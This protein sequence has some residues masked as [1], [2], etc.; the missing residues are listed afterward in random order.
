MA[1]KTD[2]FGYKLNYDKL[3]IN[4][5]NIFT[6]PTV[7]EETVFFI[8]KG[9]TKRLLFAADEIVS[10]TSYD[11]KTVYKAGDD[12]ALIDGKLHITENSSIPCITSEKYYY[13]SDSIVAIHKDGTH[14]PVYWGEDSTMVQWQV[15]VTYKHSDAFCGFSQPDNS[16]V[17][18]RF[19]K[20][21]N[22]ENSRV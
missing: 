21:L 16:A 7:F 11:R 2:I 19:I 3:D 9:E 17:Y 8:D 5:K 20:K 10:V 12:Y 13:V 18:E 14:V 6:E 22:E 1:N 15:K 4:I